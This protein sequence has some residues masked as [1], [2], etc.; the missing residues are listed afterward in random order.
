MPTTQ[1]DGADED[2]GEEEKEEN[3]D[4][5]ETVQRWFRTHI[6]DG[7]SYITSAGS[8]ELA[9]ENSNKR[10]GANTM[11]RFKR[12][13]NLSQISASLSAELYE[14]IMMNKAK[15]KIISQLVEEVLDSL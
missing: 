15:K 12:F 13:E 14:S 4:D 6:V 1:N 5:E 8:L 7:S 9:A 3:E 10:G 11:M 2:E